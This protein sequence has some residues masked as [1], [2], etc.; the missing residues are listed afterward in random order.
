MSFRELVEE[1][2]KLNKHLDNMRDI[3]YSARLDKELPTLVSALITLAAEVRRLNA[4]IE[5]L[6]TEVDVCSL[7]SEIKKDR[8]RAVK[9]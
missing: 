4:N 2:K 9:V 5:R 3:F 6:L 7:A 8:K 1:L